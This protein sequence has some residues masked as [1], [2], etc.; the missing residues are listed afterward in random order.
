MPAILSNAR[1][2]LQNSD[3]PLD[4]I[5]YI[6]SGSIVYPDG[7]ISTPAVPHGLLFTPL[8]ILKWSLTPDFSISYNAQSNLGGDTL[9]CD[10]SVQTNGTNL[11]F[12]PYNNTGSTQTI[13]WQV[14][15]YMPSNV[16]VDAPFTAAISGG[17]VYNS[18]YNYTKLLT[19]GIADVS[20]ISQSYLH[21]LGYRP[22]IE[23]W[24]ERTDGTI[25]YVNTNYADAADNQY[26]P[27]VT[28]SQVQFIKGVD[29][30]PFPYVKFHYRIY[31]DD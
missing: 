25:V 20:A 15:G 13:Y 16:N 17:F 23:T 18:D 7:G 6:N 26:K 5:V 4:K 1:N 10:L 27:I 12:F 22:Q 31:L 29:F 24:L 21:S 9:I 2:F 8:C 19:K 30:G 11:V 3:Y 28:T 14:Y